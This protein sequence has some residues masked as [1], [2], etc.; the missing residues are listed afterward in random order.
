M[1]LP[2]TSKDAVGLALAA[3]TIVL[4]VL[5]GRQPHD[6]G[7]PNAVEVDRGALGLPVTPPAV[8]GPGELPTTPSVVAFVDVQLPGVDVGPSDEHV[9]VVRH[10]VVAEIGSTGS[11]RLPDNAL[12][13]DGDGS[14]YL[15]TASETTDSPSWRPVVSGFRGE[16]ILYAGDPRRGSETGPI[17]GRLVAGRWTPSGTA[18]R[19]AQPP[20]G[21]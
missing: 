15:V 1:G 19:M 12:V 6:T 20:A 13:V 9:V 8:G 16:L 5:H 17:R 2:I 4:L 3:C 21:H 18:D 7:V 11:V 14:S 10:G